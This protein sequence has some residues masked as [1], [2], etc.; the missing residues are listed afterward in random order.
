MR[1]RTLVRVSYRSGCS[2]GVSR[3]PSGAW[4]PLSWAFRPVSSAS[5]AIAAA[6][7]DGRGIGGLAAV[8][9]AS[10]GVGSRQQETDDDDS[11]ETVAHVS[12]E[13]WG[14]TL[15]GPGR[16]NSP[17]AAIPASYPGT[18]RRQRRRR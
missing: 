18:D 11:S 12:L 6:G 16:E 8:G 15:I 17:S 7:A 13:C 1:G 4:Q 2:T 10:A 5:P 3:L 14:S 9:G